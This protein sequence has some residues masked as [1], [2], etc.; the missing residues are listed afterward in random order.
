MSQ[1]YRGAASPNPSATP[2]TT[3]TWKEKLVS[4]EITVEVALER[5]NAKL[6]QIQ[7]KMDN[8]MTLVAN[9]IGNIAKEVTRNTREIFGN[10]KKGL[11]ERVRDNESG[12][13]KLNDIALMAESIA[14]MRTELA[15][16][17]TWAESRQRW[18]RIIFTA[19]VTGGVAGF[20]AMVVWVIRQMG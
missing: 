4:E 3:P 19:V 20:L 1:G 9:E 13:L 6:D 10:G 12:I 11:L 18:E 2:R 7:Q 17:K 8:K 5:V 14:T 15:G 16:I